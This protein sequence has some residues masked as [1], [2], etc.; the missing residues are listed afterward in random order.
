M[1]GDAI[2]KLLLELSNTLNSHHKI[3]NVFHSKKVISA[4]PRVK[5]LQ[6]L[7]S[8]DKLSSKTQLPNKTL[9][10]QL[11]TK[12]TQQSSAAEEPRVDKEYTKNY[13]TIFTTNTNKFIST[14]PKNI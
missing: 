11:L 2:Q 14:T 1:H 10:E 4:D 7:K 9:M 6:V 3:P 13:V 5:V 12:H 8:L